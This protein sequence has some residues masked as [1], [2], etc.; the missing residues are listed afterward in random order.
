MLYFVGAEASAPELITVRGA[1]LLANADVCIYEDSLLNPD[2]LDL[3]PPHCQIYNSLSLA[4]QE[5]ADLLQA[6]V[7]EGQIFVRLYTGE[8]L[9]DETVRAEIDQ[10]K[11]QDLDFALCP[12]RSTTPE[13]SDFSASEYSVG[14]ESCLLNPQAWPQASNEVAAKEVEEEVT[15]SLPAS[16]VGPGPSFFSGDL[17]R[18]PLVS[19]LTFSDQG[20]DLGEKVSAWVEGHG[21][22]AS[23][24]SCPE[25]DFKAW[26]DA[27]F[28]RS[29]ALIFVGASGLAV[30]AIAP[31]LQTK[32]SHPAVLVVD[33]TGKF[34]VPLA[35]GHFDVANRLAEALAT[36]IEATPVVTTSTDRRKLWAVDN[37]A[38]L[39]DYH[40]LNPKEVKRISQRIL[41]GKLVS[42]YSD[43]PVEGP[44]PLG[45]VASQDALQADISVSWK[46]ATEEAV[47]LSPAGGVS[48]WALVT[49][50]ITQPQNNPYT[51]R[52]L[53]PSIVIG[54]GAKETV[55]A[56]L[57]SQ[58]IEEAIDAVGCNPLALCGLASLD[59][60]AQSQGI[61]EA[62]EF[63][64]LPYQAYTADQLRVAHGNFPYSD[65]MEEVAGVDSVAERAAVLATGQGE[66]IQ[67]CLVHGGVT[68]ALAQKKTVI[69]F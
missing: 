39:K 35:S 9:Q 38:Q 53:V 58:A 6:A 3:C 44:L 8:A 48:P 42:L 22:E 37:W 47:G 13:S 11:T 21:G 34:I 29:S 66:L 67:T 62:A 52:I 45:V 33:E 15:T 40:I 28:D 69:S 30:R 24:Q 27:H 68:V 17:S 50:D 7:S 23:C 36:A 25:G 64:N 55:P 57:V 14:H 41:A 56:S 2:L 46:R 32:S 26:T 20:L 10:L 60:P 16:Q 59:L 4:P 18:P 61:R 43:F 31:H 19:I 51:L 1:S 5:L 54:I 12:A 63:W 65:C 49:G